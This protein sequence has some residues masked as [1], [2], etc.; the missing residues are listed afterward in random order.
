MQPLWRCYEQGTSH[1]S[2]LGGGH[3]LPEQG[4]YVHQGLQEICRAKQDAVPEIGS[5]RTQGLL[6]IGEGAEARRRSWTGATGRLEVFEG[7]K[8]LL[9]VGLQRVI[10]MYEQGLCTS[11]TDRSLSMR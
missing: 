5:R 11:K 8:R 6:G 7:F 3:R 2:A 1:N 4:A 9:R 10:A